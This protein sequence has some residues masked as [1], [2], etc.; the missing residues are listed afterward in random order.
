MKGSNIQSWKTLDQAKVER[1][2]R[3]TTGTR[4]SRT[5]TI[6]KKRMTQDIC[7]GLV[8][9]YKLLLKQSNI[10]EEEAQDFR[11][12]FLNITEVSDE[13]QNDE[14][15]ASKYGNGER[16]TI[17]DAIHLNFQCYSNYA[18]GVENEET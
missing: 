16:S 4:L 12:N 14:F 6:C 15:T 7:E 3:K 11:L 9:G 17:R 2:L 1:P 8:K 5:K 18:R 13:T 10:Y